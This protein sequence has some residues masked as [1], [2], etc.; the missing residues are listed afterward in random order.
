MVFLFHKTQCARALA[1]QCTEFHVEMSVACKHH[2]CPHLMTGKETFFLRTS[3]RHP[4]QVDLRSFRDLLV[5][6]RKSLLIC[7]LG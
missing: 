7:S 4:G 6:F 3:Q 1:K 5:I 2:H